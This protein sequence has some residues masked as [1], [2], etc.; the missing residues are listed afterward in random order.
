MIDLC[1][2]ENL[3]RDEGILLGKEELKRE[4]TTLVGG[5]SWTGDLDKEVSGVGFRRL[6]VD[7]NDRLSGEPLSL[8]HNP[9]RDSHLCIF[10]KNKVIIASPSFYS[11]SIN[12]YRPHGVL[13]FWGFE[14]LWFLVFE[15][16]RF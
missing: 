8:L 13:G 1:P 15:V 11:E 4:Q 6:R 7:A 2:E 14:V 5:V 16:L 9:G 10:V 3:W 12:I